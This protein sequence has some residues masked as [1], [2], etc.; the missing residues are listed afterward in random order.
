MVI[1]H[2]GV[3]GMSIIFFVLS[4]TIVIMFA[5]GVLSCLTGNEMDVPLPVLQI[6]DI[7]SGN[8][9]ISTPAIM[10]QVYF[11]AMHFGLDL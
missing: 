2:I 8:T 10:Y 9:Y 3:I 6:W 5:V 7:G 11:W 4:A 1:Y